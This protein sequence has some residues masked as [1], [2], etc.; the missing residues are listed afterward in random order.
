MIIDI[1]A[2][3]LYDN[4]FVKDLIS[5]SQK[6][7]RL[8]IGSPSMVQQTLSCALGLVNPKWR[9]SSH[10]AKEYLCIEEEHRTLLGVA[11][12][13]N[14][15]LT[16]TWAERHGTFYQVHISLTI[17]TIAFPTDCR[18]SGIG[19]V[20]PISEL[21]NEMYYSPENAFALLLNTA[22]PNED[23]IANDL[24][25]MKALCKDIILTTKMKKS[26]IS[27]VTYLNLVDDIRTL[28]FVLK[29]LKVVDYNSRGQSVNIKKIE[30]MQLNSYE[31]LTDILL[32]G[33]YFL[34]KTH[35]RFGVVSGRVWR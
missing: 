30:E 19:A 25:E 11:A 28:A 20:F 33:Y 4:P 10:R 1:R 26:D 18:L 7:P 29:E 16:G 17:A 15:T 31:L 21:K 24:V 3:K 6:R 8:G 34:A 32:A 22:Q 9:K 2:T 35:D 12:S 27:N 23:N 5:G 14:N 13:R